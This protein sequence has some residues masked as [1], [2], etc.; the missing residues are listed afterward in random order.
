MVGLIVVGTAIMGFT[1]WATTPPA[2]SALATG[3]NAP[4]PRV[5]TP[6]LATPK[7]A[8]PSSVTPARARPSATPTVP[9]C[10]P[11][12]LAERAAR[13]LIVGLPGVTEPSDPLVKEVLDLGV[14]GVFLNTD[15]VKSRAQVTGLIAGIRS[16]AGRPI[17]IAT[18]EEPGRVSVFRE[19]LG[20]SPSARRLASEE[21]P[22]GARKH[23]AGVATQLAA[24]GIDMDLAPVADLDAGPSS[25]VIGDRSFS[26][27]PTVATNYAYAYAAGLADGGILPVVKHFPGQGR[28]TED[29]HFRAASVTVTLDA[30]QSSDLRPF[31]ALIR[32]GIPAVMMNHLQYSSLDPDLP[33]SLSPRAYQLLRGLG[34]RGAAITDSVGMA[35]VNG[36]WDVAEASVRAVAAGADGVLNT[37][38]R[39]A[40]D[41]RHGL[42]AAVLGGKLDESRVNEAASRMVALAGGD[43]ST[44][45][46]LSGAWRPEGDF[47]PQAGRVGAQPVP[48]QP[49]REQS[50]LGPVDAYPEKQG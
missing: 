4:T 30:L 13:T 42:V 14:G 35:A 50:Q 17:L 7:V 27:D 37:G 23:A 24:I 6:G 47:T 1:V 19:L 40:K 32:A 48:T 15:N 9:A 29:I 21:T 33:A 38:G 2:A 36:T 31:D 26:A 8:T 12:P 39:T 20:S 46:C 16:R 18:D 22:T 3:L 43:P 10:T 44:V 41:M 34:F 11:A 5:A 45:T 25:G 49:Q 28:S